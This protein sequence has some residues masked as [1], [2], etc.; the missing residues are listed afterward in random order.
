[1][2]KNF[3]LCTKKFLP[4]CWFYNNQTPGHLVVDVRRETK[5]PD[6]RRRHAVDAFVF[7]DFEQVNDGPAVHRSPE[8]AGG[9]AQVERNE[10]P[11]AAANRRAWK[12]TGRL[13][14]KK[15]ENRVSRCKIIELANIRDFHFVCIMYNVTFGYY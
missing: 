7:G 3:E 4:K 12:K 6:P 11:A 8:V 14:A 13:I 5:I 10:D 2:F 1:M 15:T 9:E